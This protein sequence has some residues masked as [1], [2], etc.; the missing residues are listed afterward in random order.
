MDAKEILIEFLLIIK[1][2]KT[3]YEEG[4]EDYDPC[5]DAFDEE[6]KEKILN[7]CKRAI[8]KGTPGAFKECEKCQ[9]QKN[10]KCEKEYLT[11]TKE[12]LDG[13]DCLFRN[14]KRK[15]S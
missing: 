12:L 5:Y 9:F 13:K 15:K 10:N 4:Y 3:G 11:C 7:L 14:I 8:N 1:D 2:A 6:T